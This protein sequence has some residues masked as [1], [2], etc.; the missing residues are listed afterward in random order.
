MKI[1]SVDTATPSCSVG[2]LKAERLLAEVTSE[3]K[4]TH[5]RHLMKMIDAAVHMAGVRIDDMDAFAVTIGPGSFTGIRIGVSTVQGFA[6]A[7]S[8][9][10]VGVSSLEALAHQAGPIPNLIC[11]LLDA[12]KDEVYAALYRFEKDGLRRVI[13][14]HVSSI[15]HVLSRIDAPCLFVGNGVQVYGD[16]IEEKLGTQAMFSGTILNKTR[17]ESVARIAMQ[18]IQTKGHENLNQLAPHY[19]RKSDAEVN[20]DKQKSPVI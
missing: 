7:L 6:M 20:S 16:L 2:I 8:K 1:L 14:E 4:Q 9:P 10:V 13:E 5:S 12:R 18:R 11:P 15:E 19:I 3:K 17:A